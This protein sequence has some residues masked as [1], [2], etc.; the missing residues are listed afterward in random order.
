MKWMKQKKSWLCLCFAAII[1]IGFTACGESNQKGSGESGKTNKRQ[2][3]HQTMSRTEAAFDGL[4]EKNGIHMNVDLTAEKTAATLDISAKGEKLRVEGTYHDQKVIMIDDD[5]FCYVLVPSTKTGT[6]SEDDTTGLED[7]V[8]TFVDIPDLL[9]EASYTTG[10]RKIQGARYE[11]EVY[12]EKDEDDQE[13][14]IFAFDGDTL[15]YII[16]EEDQQS[17]VLKVNALNGEIKKNAF[18][19]PSGYKITMTQHDED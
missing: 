1:V 13:Q 17:V 4:N 15:K 2:E 19:I 7:A 8:D 5:E 18:R 6:K 9:K 12:R 11:T 10:T 14:V 3:Q 16:A